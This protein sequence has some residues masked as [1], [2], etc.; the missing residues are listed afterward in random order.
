MENTIL[1]IGRISQFCLSRY[2][3]N[4]YLFTIPCSTR[5]VAWSNRR[6]SGRCC[7]ATSRTTPPMKS[8]T[9]TTGFGTQPR[10]VASLW[11]T[12]STFLTCSRAGSARAGSWP[13]SGRSA[14]AADLE[15]QVQCTV[16]YQD[17]ALVN[18]YHGFHQPGRLDRQQFRLLFERG[19]VTLEENRTAAIRSPWPKRQTG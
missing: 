16:R 11:S 6:R 5:C 3:N 4:L 14:P 15:E 17:G 7:T 19:E 13:P 1:F 18:F 9:Q 8:S 2:Q 10:A 12:E